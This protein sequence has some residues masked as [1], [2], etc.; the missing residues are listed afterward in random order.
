VKSQKRAWIYAGLSHPGGKLLA[1]PVA[2]HPSVLRQ[3]SRLLLVADEGA[4]RLAS[5]LEHLCRDSAVLFAL[6]RIRSDQDEAKLEKQLA[7][8]VTDF[9]PWVALMSYETLTPARW[10]AV[11]RLTGARLAWILP[12]D[13]EQARRMRGR[14][15]RVRIPS[16]HSELL[17]LRRGPDAKGLSVE[18]YAGWAGA[19]W[20]WLR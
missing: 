20:G 17:D 5:P 16:F 2:E 14:L 1:R 18:G 10:A 4:Y 13:V 9:R 11:L 15:H 12:L 8:V 6:Y 7:K 19:L 3:G